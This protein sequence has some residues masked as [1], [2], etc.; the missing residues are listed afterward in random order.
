MAARKT[1]KQ[2]T[3]S[4]PVYGANIRQEPDGKILPTV[5]QNGTTVE[6]SEMRNGWAKVDGGW[7]RAIYLK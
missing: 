5:L 2:Y 6:V 4:T 1:A 7:L 3:V